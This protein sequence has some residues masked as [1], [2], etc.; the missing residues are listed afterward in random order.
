MELNYIPW[1]DVLIPDLELDELETRPLNKWGRMRKKYLM[2]D[3]YLT[4]NNMVMEG[5]LAQHLLEVEQAAE[6]R[7]ELLLPQLEAAVGITEELKAR[8]MMKW[9][10]LKNTCKA[11]V[12]EIIQAELI[13]V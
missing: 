12:E 4:F 2:E 11:Q 8:D 5:T 6:A 1:G 10:G 9:V 3:R 7:M 13:F